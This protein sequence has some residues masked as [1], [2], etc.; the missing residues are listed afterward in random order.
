MFSL[1]IYYPLSCQERKLQEGG[2][3]LNVSGEKKIH[4]FGKKKKEKKTFAQEFIQ[5]VKMKNAVIDTT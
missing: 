1:S 2:T 4:Y 5:H 3:H